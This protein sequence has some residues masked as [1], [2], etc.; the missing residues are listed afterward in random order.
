VELTTETQREDK[1]RERQGR[2]SGR[3][4]NHRDAENTEGRQTQRKAR[5]KV[6]K[7]N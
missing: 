6:R 3:G 2:K 4:I 5:K 1:R 7:R